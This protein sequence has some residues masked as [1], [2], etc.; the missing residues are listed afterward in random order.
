[1]PFW[2]EHQNKITPEERRLMEEKGQMPNRFIGISTAP[3]RDQ[4][5]E[6][7]KRLFQ[8]ATKLES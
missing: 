1:M 8:G 7:K 6:V 2:D 3:M 4:L 5:S